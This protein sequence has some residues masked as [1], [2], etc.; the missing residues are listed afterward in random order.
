MSYEE[1]YGKD[2]E[3]W[4]VEDHG[5]DYH[6]D[7]KNRQTS[8]VAIEA[9]EWWNPARMLMKVIYRK[10]RPLFTINSPRLVRLIDKANQYF[11]THDEE[12]DPETEK[13]IRVIVLRELRKRGIR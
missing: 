5:I 11:D 2:W 8:L 9:P 4:T 6:L 10:N 7:I 12:L 13:R 3:C 1:P